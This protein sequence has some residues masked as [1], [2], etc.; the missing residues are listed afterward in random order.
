METKKAIKV[1]RIIESDKAVKLAGRVASIK[2]KIAALSSALESE[3]AVLSIEL[4]NC[5]VEEV[6][7][8]EIKVGDITKHIQTHLNNVQLLYPK[9]HL[10]KV[11]KVNGY[12]FNTYY[13]YGINSDS[14]SVS[15]IYEK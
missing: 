8:T 9:V 14:S 13:S 6:D 2:R 1:N 7:A 15:S 5:D 3:T 12:P 11:T 10:D 4:D